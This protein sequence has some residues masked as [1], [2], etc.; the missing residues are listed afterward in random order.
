MAFRA[1]RVVRVQPAQGLDGADRRGRCRCVLR[2]D[3]PLVPRR[4][5][6]SAAVPVRYPVTA[7][8]GGCRGLAVQLA[9][10]GN[11]GRGEAARR[12]CRPPRWA[13]ETTARSG[14]ATTT[15]QARFRRG[16]G[17]GVSPG[18]G[19]GP[20]AAGRRLLQRRGRSASQLLGVLYEFR[21]SPARNRPDYGR[22][23]GSDRGGRTAEVFGSQRQPC[24]GRGHEAPRGVDAPDVVGP[25]WLRGDGRGPADLRPLANLRVMFLGGTKVTDAGLNYLRGFR[26]LRQLYLPRE[27]V[28]D[29]GVEGSS[30]FCRTA[31]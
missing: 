15:R 14:F 21:F 30:G 20:R 2:A 17:G 4:P 23:A 19:V 13:A 7:C 12:G 26:R 10:D 16:T 31:E 9:R 22:V 5:C 8:A 18:P 27:H 24:H 25:V 28:T 3:A 29:A 6:V 1:V 11:A